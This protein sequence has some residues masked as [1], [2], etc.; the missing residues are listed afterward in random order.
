MQRKTGDGDSD[1]QQKY[2]TL[3]PLWRSRWNCYSLLLIQ[4]PHYLPTLTTH[5]LWC[6]S[7]SLT[8]N[9]T[10]RNKDNI[11]IT[12]LLW[13][14]HK[15]IQN[16]HCIHRMTHFACK[17]SHFSRYVPAYQNLRVIA[18]TIMQ[19]LKFTNYWL[20]RHCI[21]IFRSDITINIP[22]LS[23]VHFCF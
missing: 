18:C 1:Q 19:S 22:M 21:K 13:I 8:Y 7:Y 16:P 10:S 11:R 14:L 17:T 3:D 23:K 2:G 20:K 6:K 15:T 12:I 5:E 9:N 4:S